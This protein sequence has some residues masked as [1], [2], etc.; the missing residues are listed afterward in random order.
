[1]RI[2]VIAA[3]ALLLAAGCTTTSGTGDPAAA[4]TPAGQAVVSPTPNK[5]DAA[6]A[7]TARTISGYCTLA[8]IGISAGQFFANKPKVAAAINYAGAVVNSYC[9]GPPPTDV[10]TALDALKAAYQAVATANA[11]P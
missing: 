3:A 8:R 6:I 9:N 5:V 7:K 1:M 2:H 4:A 10:A 11:A